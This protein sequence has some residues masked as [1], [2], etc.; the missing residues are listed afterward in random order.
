MPPSSL[1]AAALAAGPE[2]PSPLEPPSFAEHPRR[3][4]DDQI[5][6]K[7]LALNLERAGAV[8]PPEVE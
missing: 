4:G 1:P 7:L 2:D 8:S 3:G 6:E 5:L